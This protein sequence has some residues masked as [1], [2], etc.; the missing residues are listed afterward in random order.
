LDS[1]G[2]GWRAYGF[3]EL[4]SILEKVPY[5]SAAWTRKYPGIERTLQDEPM[6]P[7]GNIVSGNVL[8]K[9]G[10][11]TDMLEAAFRSKSDVRE[12]TSADGEW[13]VRV[14]GRTLVIGPR[15]MARIPQGMHSLARTYGP[16]VSVPSN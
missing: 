9:S 8:L 12:N 7:K 10:R 11:D 4:K 16:R 6:A 15:A 14:T 3:N 13:D 1:R 2:L 5:Q